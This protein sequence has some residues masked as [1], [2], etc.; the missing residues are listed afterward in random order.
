MRVPTGAD[1][2]LS[3]ALQTIGGRG[4]A[5]GSY[6][7]PLCG[8]REAVHDF[9]FSCAPEQLMKHKTASVRDRLKTA[10]VSHEVH[11]VKARQRVKKEDL[12]SMRRLD[13][14]QDTLTLYKRTLIQ[15]ERSAEILAK[16]PL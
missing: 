8:K 15:I 16:A 12:A 11:L 7:C 3:Y 1:A 13:R 6:I 5:T 2:Y 9:L 14:L 4:D 10:I